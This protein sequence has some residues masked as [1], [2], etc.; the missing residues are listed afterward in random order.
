LSRSARQCALYSPAG[1]VLGCV[2]MVKLYFH[3]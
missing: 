2:L 1:I 3:E